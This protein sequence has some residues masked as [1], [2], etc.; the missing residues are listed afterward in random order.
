M[1]PEPMI[2]VVIPCYNERR[3][4][5]DLVRR[6][7]EAPVARKQ[8]ILVDDCSTDGTTELIRAEIEPLPATRCFAPR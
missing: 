2:A 8:L 7:R 5:A 4:L 6:V 1:T 3:T